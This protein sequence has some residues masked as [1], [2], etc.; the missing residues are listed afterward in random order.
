M[1]RLSAFESAFDNALELDKISRNLSQQNPASLGRQGW[2]KA[3]QAA[4]YTTAWAK[5]QAETAAR[6]LGRGARGAGNMLASAPQPI[7]TAGATALGAGS[8][9]AAGA[10]GYGAFNML[11]GRAPFDGPNMPGSPEAKDAAARQQAQ[12]QLNRYAQLAQETQ[13]K[14]GEMAKIADQ[15]R[16]MTGLDIETGRA[17]NNLELEFAMQQ[18][19]ARRRNEYLNQ[20]LYTASRVRER[21]ANMSQNVAA[22]SQNAIQGM[23]YLR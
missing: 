11:S 1:S 4:D 16:F 5:D 18:D 3:K 9:L 2:E 6:A 17:L 20:P 21:L 23:A 10:L 7:K 19:D 15:M 8:L 12:D 14:S 22:Y 13:L